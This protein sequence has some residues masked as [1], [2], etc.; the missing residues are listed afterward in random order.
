MLYYIISNY[1]M[2]YDIISNDIGVRHWWWRAANGTARVRL[3]C[4]VPHLNEREHPRG[5]V[6]LRAEGFP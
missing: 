5:L 2:L 3:R 1:I 4:A 6:L